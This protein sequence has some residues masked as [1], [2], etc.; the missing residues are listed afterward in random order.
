MKPTASSQSVSVVARVHAVLWGVFSL[1]GFIAAFL[2][3]V[4]IYVN[5]IAYP[6]GLWP[7]TRLDPTSL[8]VSNRLSTL[9]IFLTIAGSLYHGIF[10]FQ[11]TLPELGLGRFKEKLAAL[12]YAVIGTG[13]VMLIIFLLA[14][15]P[16]L[17]RLP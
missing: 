5:N 12:G 9:F 6:L 1:G 16:G 2:L 13:I 7:T 14:L 3:P 4:L 17:L 10:R 11:T 15:N 8:M